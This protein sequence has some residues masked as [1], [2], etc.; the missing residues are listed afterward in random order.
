MG[1][2]GREEIWEWLREIITKIEVCKRGRKRFDWAIKL[3]GKC[4]AGE[5]GRKNIQ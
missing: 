2:R 5:R 1:K 4:E 3:V